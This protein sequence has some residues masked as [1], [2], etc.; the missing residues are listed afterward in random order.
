[1][2]QRNSII[3]LENQT[4]NLFWVKERTQSKAA[5]WDLYLNELLILLA[6]YHLT[7]FFGVPPAPFNNTQDETKCKEN[8]EILQTP[9]VTDP[10]KLA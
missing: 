2:I 1:M 3:L 9:S 10:P 4:T 6:S 7:L 5:F 8:R